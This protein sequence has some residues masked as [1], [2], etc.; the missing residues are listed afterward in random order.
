[1]ILMFAL[2]A[3]DVKKY[4][5][6]R[7]KFNAYFVVRRNVIYERARFNRR[8]QAD[9]ESIES[10]LRDLYELIETCEYG[11]MRDEL[12]RDRIVVGIRDQRLSEALQLDDALTLTTALAKVRAKA[13]IS[14]QSES[15]AQLVTPHADYVKRSKNKSDASNKLPCSPP[16]KQS[17]KQSKKSCFFC[18]KTPKHK[19]SECPARESVCNSC[20]KK[21][22]WNTVCQK[23][24]TVTQVDADS[25]DDDFIGTVTVFLC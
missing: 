20:G 16:T 4:Q 8:C 25:S 21:G 2:S 13:M 14:K 17:S 1:M 12:L 5:T 15:L 7:D 19:R 22:H 6:V 9:G 24:K 18:G 3:E 10:Y 11:A 23:K